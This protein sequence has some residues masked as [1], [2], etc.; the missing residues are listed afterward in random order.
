[1]PADQNTA[2]IAAIRAVLRDP[3]AYATTM[4]VLA[5]DTFGDECLHDPKDPD[6]GPWHPET[7]RSMLEEEYGCPVAQGNLDR[8]MAAV[9]VVTTDLFFQ[10]A[11]RFIQLA[12]VLSGSEFDPRVWDKADA[13]ECAWAI[14]EALILSPPD[15]DDHE[16]FSADVR[17]YLAAV[18]KDEGYMTP[19]DVLK[20]AIGGDL[21][22]LVRSDLADDPETF[23]SVY[24]AQ[25]AKT[26]EIEQVIRDNLT[27]LA[28]QLEALPLKTGS[29]E[30][31]LG[32]V[33]QTL[34]AKGPAPAEAGL[35][36]PAIL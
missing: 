35:P 23:Q 28:A 29:A 26:E 15:H 30:E 31:F 24:S 16:P 19:P 20:I 2:S 11:D 17:H 6:R 32:R 18:L 25:K 36:N 1:M 34:R 21:S 5:V 8:L 27:A 3:D 7:F 13:A 14:T 33:E 9:T 4:L 10:N 12:N 22:S